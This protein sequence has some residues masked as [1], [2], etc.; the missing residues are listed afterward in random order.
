MKRIGS[1]AVKPLAFCVL[2]ILLSGCIKLNM[3]LTVSTDNTVSGSAIVA[4]DK[5]LV[6][7]TGQPVDQIFG[8]DTIAPAGTQGV[9]TKDYEDDTFVGQEITFEGAPLSA[10]AESEDADALKIVRE[11]DVFTV[12]GALDMT[13]DSGG[14]ATNEA[15]ENALA[16]ADIRI[17]I[18]FPGP[19]T[20]SNGEVDGNTVSWSPKVGQRTELQAQASA[21]PSGSS[22][23]T[24]LWIAI[25]VAVAVVVIS[26]V[27]VMRRRSLSTAVPA[28]PP[29]TE[30]PAGPPATEVPAGPPTTEGPAGPPAP[31]TTEP[32]D[33]T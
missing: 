11:G 10:L 27:M 1:M 20:S 23:S 7:L 25:A 19:V 12:T 16:S 31:P 5:Q 8:G 29:A 14:D 3:D 28:G 6:A 2:V 18:T 33:P 4:I 13:N 32:E 24:V 26:G 30:V 22:S 17:S 15:V 21:I 9:T